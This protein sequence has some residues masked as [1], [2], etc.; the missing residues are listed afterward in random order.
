MKVLPMSR[1]AFIQT[2]TV[3]G[4]VVAARTADALP[5]D[6]RWPVGCFSR[7][8][9]Q[10]FNTKRQPIT[11]PQPANWGLDAALRGIKE[12]GY[13]TVGLLT[14]QPDEPVIGSEAADAYLA[15]LR[16]KIVDAG[17][18]ATMGALRTQE[19][20]PLAA[21]IAD[22]RL[23]ID[24]AH[25]LG[26]EWLLTFGVNDSAHY[27]TY[28]KTMSDAA[29]YAQERKIK[30][31]MKPHG[32]ASGAAAEILKCLEKINR[33]NFAIWYDAGNILYYTG[34]D[35]VEEL[36]PIVRHVTGFCA[37]DCLAPKGD[38]MIQFGAGKVD[39]RGVFEELKKAGFQGPIFV[40][41]CG[42]KTF[43]EVTAGARAN[44]LFLER[45]LAAL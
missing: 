21:A 27:D 10:A 16:N 40:E 2:A 38:V 34:K 1:R 5:E 30:L 26:L 43:D 3:A 15:G 37:K 17:L 44:R 14:R 39:F 33:P 23:Q 6:S 45:L 41:C 22:C 8:W 4:A 11:Q 12:A 29:D 7:P 24:H 19:Q 9:M 18:K 13:S 32:G 25:A 31:V 35:P 28:F 42:G 20:A 36:K